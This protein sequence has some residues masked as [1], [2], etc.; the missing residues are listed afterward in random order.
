MDFF[1]KR[2]GVVEDE[3]INA[4]HKSRRMFCIYK[5]KLIIAEA[6]LPYSHA[7]WFEK[8]GLISKENDEL[9]SKI[10]RGIVDSE[11]D[12]YFYKGYDFQIDK[13]AEVIFFNHLS[14]L[15]TRLKIKQDAKVFGGLIKQE[16]G[17][18]WIPRKEYGMV[19]ELFPD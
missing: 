18:S 9:M 11:G 1:E 12:I 19:K 14:E 13:D 15:I 16:K 5:D 17:L 2:Y 6:N 7:V 8:E 10:V 3:K 4:F